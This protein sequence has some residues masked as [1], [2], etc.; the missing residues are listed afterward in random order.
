LTDK[1][2]FW[3]DSF[4]KPTAMATKVLVAFKTRKLQTKPQQFKPFLV[5]LLPFARLYFQED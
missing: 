1:Q 5:D 4:L 3:K 2:A